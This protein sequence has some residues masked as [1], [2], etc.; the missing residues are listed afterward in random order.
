MDPSILSERSTLGPIT[1]A[2]EFR[3]RQG[4]IVAPTPVTGS[5]RFVVISTAR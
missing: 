2:L 4:V 1:V 5:P 3:I